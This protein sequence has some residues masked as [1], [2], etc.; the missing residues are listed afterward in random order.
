MNT[1]FSGVF[2]FVCFW[3]DYAEGIKYKE[4]S[5]KSPGFLTWQVVLSNA[6]KIDLPQILS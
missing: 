3:M 1:F 2:L 6:N 4:E 5:R